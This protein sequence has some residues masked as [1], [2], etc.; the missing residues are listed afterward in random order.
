STRGSRAEE[1]R[2]QARGREPRVRRTAGETGDRGADARVR[3]LRRLSEGGDRQVGH[4]RTQERHKSRLTFALLLL[5]AMGAAAAQS[6]P[7]HPVRMIVPYAAGGASDVTARIVAAGL[8]ERLR[9]PIVVENRTGAGGAIGAEVAAKATP[10]G[11]TVLLGS[12][13][14]VV[15]L[16]AVARIPYD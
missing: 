16:P 5:I 4:C 10:D 8:G 1:E 3:R 9:Q 6:Y 12:A 11:Y 15:M 14:E 13:S 2:A 7:T